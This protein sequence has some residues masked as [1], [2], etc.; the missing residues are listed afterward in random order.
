[1]KRTFVV[2]AILALVASYAFVQVAMAADCEVGLYSSYING[3]G[4][5]L[6]LN[7]EPVIQGSCTFS[8][9]NGLYVSP[10]FSQAP[11]NPGLSKSSANEFD[12]TFGWAGKVSE[13]LSAN[14]YAS[15]YDLTN[16]N[17]FDGTNGDMVNSGGV[18]RYSITSNT[19]VYG[20]VDGYHGIGSR[21]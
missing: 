6:G 5:K 19:S 7:H 17:M 21:G 11:S 10:W 8:A 20:S 4:K 2:L 15:Y 13:R 14:V 16:D 1:M 9:A 12:L 18:L 3:S